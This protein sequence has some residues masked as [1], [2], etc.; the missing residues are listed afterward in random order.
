MNRWAGQ[1]PSLQRG[2]VLKARGRQI[3]EETC[4]QR[5]RRGQETRAELSLSRRTLMI[6]RALQ[7]ESFANQLSFGACLL[8]P[9]KRPTA[10]L[11]F[12]F[13]A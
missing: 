4:G 11:L 1:V 2:S 7:C 3:Q 13:W 10:G 8:T 12:A 6:P 5:L 9:P